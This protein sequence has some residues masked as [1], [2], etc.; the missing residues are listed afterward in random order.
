MP[1]STPTESCT[2][3]VEFDEC[4]NVTPDDSNCQELPNALTLRYNGGN[5]AQSDNRQALSMVQ[6]SD[7]TT[8]PPPSSG[9]SYIVAEEHGGGDVYFEGFVD[10]GEDYTLA[11]SGKSLPAD[12]SITVYDPNGSSNPGDIVNVANI[13]QTLTFHTSCSQPLFLKDKYGAHQ[14]VEWSNDLQ[15]IV[16]CFVATQTGPVTLTNNFNQAITLLEANIITNFLPQPIDKTDEV[17]GQILM[18]GE[19][20]ELCSADV[21][22]DLTDQDTQYTFLVTIVGEVSNGSITCNG[23]DSLECSA[24]VPSLFPSASPTINPV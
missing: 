6:C 17:V 20:V 13:Q 23:A 21:T 19:S 8:N 10:V 5:C 9:G 18:P 4:F 2:I 14:V 16:S 15:G 12:M 1:S 11:L 22:V 3:D 7:S 24:D